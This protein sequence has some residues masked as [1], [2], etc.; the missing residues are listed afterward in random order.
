MGNLG[1]FARVASLGVVGLSATI[2]G[3]FTIGLARLG[4]T[5]KTTGAHLNTAFGTLLGP[6]ANEEVRKR[7]D[8]LG[9]SAEALTNAIIPLQ[10]A[11]R[12]RGTPGA[13]GRQ[14]GVAATLEQ[15]SQLGGGQPGEGTTAAQGLFEAFA[16]QGAARPLQPQ[17]LTAEML[18]KLPES[19][20]EG[21]AKALGAG[22][23]SKLLTQISAGRRVSL[24]QILQGLEGGRGDVQQRYG[25]LGPQQQ[26]FTGEL[27]KLWERLNLGLAPTGSAIS[28]GLLQAGRFLNQPLPG[29]GGGQPIISQGP[30]GDWLRKL[31]EAGSGLNQLSE[32]TTGAAQ[33][34]RKFQDAQDKA[35]E[36]IAKQEEEQ[37]VRTADFALQ[38]AALGLKYEP[39]ETQSRLERD[40]LGVERAGENKE[41]AQLNLAKAIRSRPKPIWDE[42]TEQLTNWLEIAQS[43][44]NIRRAKTEIRS[45]DLEER[46][47]GLRFAK[48]TEGAPI[49]HQLQQ[50]KYDEAQT[51]NL[52]AITHNTAQIATNTSGGGSGLASALEQLTAAIN[53]LGGGGQKGG[54]GGTEAPGGAL[55]GFYIGDDFIR[56]YAHGG[57]LSGVGGPREDRNLG[58]FSHG[59]YVV[60]AAST[61]RYRPI[62]EAINAGVYA[63]GGFILPHFAGGSAVG[64]PAGGLSAAAASGASHSSGGGAMPDIVVHSHFNLD[65]SEL[66]SSVARNSIARQTS[67]G[68]V[69]PSWMR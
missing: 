48:D 7:A 27:G 55:G 61:S 26:T 29:F 14:I 21:I 4:D 9:V 13:P 65:G 22:D 51:Q 16:Q 47:T 60:N 15:I 58:W 59:E 64:A 5:A 35:A 18:T 46:D 49:S 52:E 44:L 36:T 34:M 38:Q 42:G 24:D 63:D 23:S 12:R 1:S 31:N 41:Q 43:N 66:T 45:A 20:G 68:A 11:Q 30:E 25:Q 69:M 67:Q 62:I 6:K 17:S 40:E 10:E 39:A 53:R 28:T 2:A 57:P 19:I 56:A 32:S 50:L 3:A 37:K 54:G 8:E 33:T